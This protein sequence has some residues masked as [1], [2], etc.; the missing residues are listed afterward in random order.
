MEAICVHQ[1]MNKEDVVCV[2]THTHTH[3]HTREFCL[4]NLQVTCSGLGESKSRQE[5]SK[6]I[7]ST[8]ITYQIIFILQDSAQMSNS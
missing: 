3:T 6:H 1:Q 5:A 7:G 2:Y 4:L 8:S